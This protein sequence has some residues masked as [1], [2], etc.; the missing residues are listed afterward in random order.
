MQQFENEHIQP[1][2]VYDMACFCEAVCL[3][4]H[5]CHKEGIKNEADSLR[6]CIKHLKHGFIDETFKARLN[7]N[8]SAPTVVQQPQQAMPE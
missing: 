6:D 5:I 7:I 3:M 8:E 4:I 1:N 2:P